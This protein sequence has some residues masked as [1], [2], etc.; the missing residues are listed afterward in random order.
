MDKIIGALTFKSGVYT[1]VKKDA[2]FTS[3]SWGIVV[4]SALLGGLGSNTSLVRAGRIVPWL[5]GVIGTTVFT[6]LGFILA[7]ALVAAL[8][9][10]V[11]DRSEKLAGLQR[12]FGLARVWVA[13]TAVGLLTVLSPT[14]AGFT[15]L[16]G[17]IAIGLWLFAWGMSVR[18]IFGLDWVQSISLVTVGLIVMVAVAVI[19]NTL[20]GAFGL[21]S[22]TLF[23]LF[24]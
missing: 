15:G 8:A 16:I 17:L 24:G 22:T 13:F 4:V 7:C 2:G 19:A 14:L 5:L 12:A 9:K 11:F 6:L 23:Q 20:L 18:E 21:M 10:A 3:A 1:Q